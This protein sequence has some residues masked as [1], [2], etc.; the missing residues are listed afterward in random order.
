MLVSIILPIYN[1]QRFIKR[2][3]TSLLEQSHSEIE[4][5]IIDDGS[6]DDTCKIIN[7]F[8]LEDNRVRLIS[9]HDNVGITKALSI[10]LQSVRG[11]VIMRHDIDEIA[12]PERIARSVR[13]LIKS[14]SIRTVVCESHKKN[15]NRFLSLTNVIRHSSVMF[16]AHEDIYYNEQFK[17]AQDYEL[18]LRLRNKGWKFQSLKALTTPMKNNDS[19]SI[20]HVDEQKSYAKQA[21]KLHLTRSER[22]LS[23]CYEVYQLLK[24]KI[25]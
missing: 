13:C 1:G 22:L 3:I 16:W 14:K 17:Y 19:I 23:T 6:T 15:I 18:W 7:E 25:L 8:M 24:Q 4:I 21:Q 11:E 10:G 20:L 2:S 12:N 5:I 9:L